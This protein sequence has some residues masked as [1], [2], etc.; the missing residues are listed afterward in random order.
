MKL[1]Y[2]QTKAAFVEETHLNKQIDSS[3]GIINTVTQSKIYLY[4]SEE[5]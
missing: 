5:Y 3:T 2:I 4:H 1:Q